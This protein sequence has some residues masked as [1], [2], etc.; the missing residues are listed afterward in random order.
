MS[1]FFIP[2]H[3]DCSSWLFIEIAAAD[4]AAIAAG[5]VDITLF[6][7]GEIELSQV[8]STG[9]GVGWWSGVLVSGTVVIC[10]VSNLDQYHCSLNLSSATYGVFFFKPP[11]TFPSCRFEVKKLPCASGQ[12]FGRPNWGRIFK[13]WPVFCAGGTGAWWEDEAA[14]PR[15]FLL[16]SDLWKFISKMYAGCL[17]TL[18]HIKLVASGIGL[19]SSFQFQKCGNVRNKTDKTHQRWRCR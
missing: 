16:E 11:P 18:G 15:S 9:T 3:W 4:S 2:F 8:A 19:L 17:S 1:W 13:Q 6:L 14:K 12:F 7:T 5:I 10:S